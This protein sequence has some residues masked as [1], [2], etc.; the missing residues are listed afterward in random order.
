MPNLADGTG[1]A[2][3]VDGNLI[4]IDLDIADGSFT[5]TELNTALS[6]ATL[7]DQSHGHTVSDVSDFRGE[8]GT[9]VD[10]ISGGAGFS[11]VSGAVSLDLSTGR[12]FH[13]TMTGNITSLSFSNVPTTTAYATVWTWVLAIDATGGYAL[14]GTPTVTWVDGGDFDDLDLS[15]NAVNIVTFWRIGSV[16]YAALLYNGSLRLDP[17]RL[18]FAEDG[19]QLIVVDAA[20]TVDLSSVTNVEADG[21]AGT[22]TLTFQKNGV[23]ASGS[24]SLASGD[25]LKVTLASSTTPTAVLIPRAL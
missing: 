24:T 5:L 8:V 7:V 11:S 10:A 23:S 20:E 18:S 19:D 2:I 25:V 9:Y 4:Y 13:Q 6:D 22:G 17:Y 21:T 16:T 15:A 1:T 12:A 3:R 14:S